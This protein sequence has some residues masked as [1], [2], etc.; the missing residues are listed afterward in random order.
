MSDDFLNIEGGD[1]QR[2]AQVAEGRRIASLYTVFE[3]D[4]RGRELLKL[5][6][7]TLLNKRTPTNAQHTEYA[8]NEAMRAFVAGIHQQMKLA[9]SG[10]LA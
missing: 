5:W 9:K 1:R 8:A 3:T 4:E 10:R 6:D 7:E 2:Q